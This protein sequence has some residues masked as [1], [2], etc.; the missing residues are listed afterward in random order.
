M[1]LTKKLLVIKLGKMNKLLDQLDISKRSHNRNFYNLLKK[2]VDNQCVYCSVCDKPIDENHIG[3]TIVSNKTNGSY[4]K[5]WYHVKCS[6][7]INITT[8][9]NENEELG[10]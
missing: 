5:K 2:C 9:E 10:N 1:T 6:E 3:Q 8:I 7:D 4:V